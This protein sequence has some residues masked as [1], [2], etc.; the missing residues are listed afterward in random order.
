MIGGSFHADGDIEPICETGGS[1]NGFRSSKPPRLSPAGRRRPAVWV[2]GL[3]LVAVGAAVA[4]SAALSAGA[5]HD[6]LA[7]RGRCRRVGFDGRRFA[8]GAGV[9]GQSIATVPAGQEPAVMGQR[10][11]VDL[12]PNSAC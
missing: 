10:T 3:A 9:G 4:V 11:A 8:D 1:G 12:L 5:K 2:A 6:V 7:T